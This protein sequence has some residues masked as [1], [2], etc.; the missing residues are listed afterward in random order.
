MIIAGEILSVTLGKSRKL[1]SAEVTGKQLS[2][3][4]FTPEIFYEDNWRQIT[5]TMRRE[6]RRRKRRTV[7]ITE[8]SRD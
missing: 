2:E 8:T 1:G 6:G 3:C 5:E 4:N 7:R